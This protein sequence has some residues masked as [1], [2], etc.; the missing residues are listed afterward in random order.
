MLLL[1]IDKLEEG[2]II[3]IRSESRISEI[4]RR[5]TKSR[6]SHA[7]L[8]VGVSSVI[9]SD[10]Y[11]VQSN[12]IQRILIKK[13]DDAVVLRIID[14]NNKKKLIDVEDFARQKIGTEYSTDEAKI[15]A[16]SKELEAKEPNR[17]FCTRFIA[18][19]FESAGI[20][21]V[22]NS[23]Y[24]VPEDILNSPALEVVKDVLRQASQKEIEFAN[25]ENPLAKQRD[26]HNSIFRK[27][28]ELSGHDI[29][30]FEQ[31]S[32][33]V[34]QKPEFDSEITEFIRSS[35]YLTM[36][37]DDMEKN[38]WH[39]DAEKMIEHYQHPE[40]IVEN[41]IFFAT[42]EEKSRERLNTTIHSLIQIN[43]I[44]PR[45]YFK[46]EIELYRKLLNFSYQR[47]TEALRVLKNF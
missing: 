42:T 29:Q 20:K 38:P 26:I 19:A 22:D 11:G 13:E 5:L 15:A 4:V 40:L 6:Y 23:D 37:E 2:D 18:Q 44:Y 8:Y 24:C 17:Q 30:T 1:N 35:G 27:A 9:D 25:S 28:R 41:A 12:N 45:E 33:L 47:Q 10:G 43:K 3:L 21:L 7:I 32:D 34:I 16:L 46:M 36:T 39:Y 14:N 31:L